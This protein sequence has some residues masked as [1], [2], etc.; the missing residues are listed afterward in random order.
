MV[1]KVQDAAMELFS[2]HM[3]H[4]LTPFTISAA[5]AMYD[6]QSGA[7]YRKGYQDGYA[8]GAQRAVLRDWGG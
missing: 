8:A 7:Q 6:V 2:E 1:L 4:S 5:V 3:L